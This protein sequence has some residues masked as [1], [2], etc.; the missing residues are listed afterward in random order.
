MLKYPTNQTNFVPVNNTSP[1]VK[2]NFNYII[3]AHLVDPF[4]LS[5]TFPAFIYE[6]LSNWLP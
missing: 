3:L 5:R 4:P 1:L 6:F 2:L